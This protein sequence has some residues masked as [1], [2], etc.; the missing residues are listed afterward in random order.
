MASAGF[1]NV[2]VSNVRLKFRQALRRGTW[3]PA[4]SANTRLAMLYM[5]RNEA[6][7]EEVAQQ[8]REGNY[9]TLGRRRCFF[10][11]VGMDS[12]GGEINAVYQLGDHC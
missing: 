11:D 10:P 3:K 6:A 7:F 9:G 12:R 8:F 4:Y 5:K 1:K 2:T